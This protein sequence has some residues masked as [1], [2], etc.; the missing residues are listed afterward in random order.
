MRS[1]ET[2]IWNYGKISG[3]REKQRRRL[4]IES[5]KEK[6]HD[7]GLEKFRKKMIGS[8]RDRKGEKERER[9]VIRLEEI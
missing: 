5:K 1:K 2:L 6:G 3:K 7:L 8:K 9:T 4:R